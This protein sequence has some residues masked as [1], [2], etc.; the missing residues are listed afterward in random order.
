MAVIPLHVNG[1]ARI[2]IRN[3]FDFTPR[4]AE[5]SPIPGFLVLGFTVE[6]VDPQI[7]FGLFEWNTDQYG[8]HVPGAILFIG[9]MGKIDMEL[10]RW[11][12]RVLDEFVAI[13]P[14]IDAGN[15][16]TSV[17]GK[18]IFSGEAI[19]RDPDTAG[20][21]LTP[22]LRI[23]SQKLTGLN[24]EVAYEFFNCYVLPPQAFRLGTR[25]T[26]MKLTVRC[27]PQDQVENG[28]VYKRLPRLSIS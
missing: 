19:S 9:Q 14:F 24:Q 20:I 6:G 3:V 23:E 5:I 18:Q 27:L 21:N 25:V 4:G 22:S 10:I 7:E 8:T 12:Q 26:R 2:E 17:I 1:P 15:S 13:F 11:N 28:Q 16:N